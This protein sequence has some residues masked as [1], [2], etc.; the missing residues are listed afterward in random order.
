[1][2]TLGGGG[3]ERDQ[4]E[5]EEGIPGDAMLGST[6]R[7]WLIIPLFLFAYYVTRRRAI[8]S[9]RAPAPL[10]SPGRKIAKLLFHVT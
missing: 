2:R 9:S 6:L 10:L 3:S 1:M 5:E 7:I 4:E 8:N